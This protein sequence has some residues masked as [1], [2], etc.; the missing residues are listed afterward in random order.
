VPLSEGA[1]RV[2]LRGLIAG[3]GS[4]ETSEN[5]ECQ[6]AAPR[7]G[8]LLYKAH[9]NVEVAIGPS[10]AVRLRSEHVRRRNL[11]ERTWAISRAQLAARAAAAFASVRAA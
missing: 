3:L 4:L 1:H 2:K 9:R 7:F 8:A 11:G 5:I 6:G 10:C